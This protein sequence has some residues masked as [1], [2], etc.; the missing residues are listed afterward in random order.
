MDLEQPSSHTAFHR[1]HRVAGGHILKLQQL[2]AE[3]EA[4]NTLNRAALLISLLQS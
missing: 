1:M 3:M 4:Q 2:S